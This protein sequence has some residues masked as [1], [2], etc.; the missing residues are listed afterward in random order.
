LQGVTGC[1]DKDSKQSDMAVED[2]KY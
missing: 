2:V 1:E